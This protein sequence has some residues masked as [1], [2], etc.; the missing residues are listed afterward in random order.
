MV[1]TVRNNK[2]VYHPANWKKIVRPD[3]W[4][5]FEKKPKLLATL[6]MSKS[7]FALLIVRKLQEFWNDI[8]KET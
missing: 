6:D 3:L 2:V 1:F 4:V 8:M 5:K 7:A